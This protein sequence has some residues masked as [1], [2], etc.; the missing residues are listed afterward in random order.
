MTKKK[1]IYIIIASTIYFIILFSYL[2]HEP[3]NY[4]IEGYN[5]KK[6]ISYL[7]IYEIPNTA[8][9]YYAGEPGE[10]D[11]YFLIKNPSQNE[12]DLKETINN[13]LFKEGGFK[14]ILNKIHNEVNT[15]SEIS[16]SFYFPGKDFPIGWIPTYGLFNNDEI[17]YHGDNRL[18]WIY[19]KDG[20]DFKYT[21]YMEN[22]L[23]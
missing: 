3:I 23:N 18:A 17:D 22:L 20:I 8:R 4:L 10:V 9:F 5:F 15:W 7:N 16:I 2:F 1:K 12:N 21:F 19:T 13:Y 11:I 14:N 6:S